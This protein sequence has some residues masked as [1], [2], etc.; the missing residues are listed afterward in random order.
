MSKEKKLKELE[1]GYEAGIVK[2]EEYLRKRKEI[3]SEAGKEEKAVEEQENSDENTTKGSDRMLIAG[4]AVVVV[5]FFGVFF[6]AKLAK[7]PPKTIEDLHRLNIEGKLKPEEGYLYK[8]VY[9]FVNLDGFWYTQLTS[10]SGKR[11]YDMSLRYGPKD[12]ENIP[13]SGFLDTELFNNA[14]EYYVT[15]NPTGRDFSH[16]AVAVADFNQH[17]V[18]VFAK[19]PIAACDK[20]ETAACEGRPIITCNNTG[21][22][23][24]YIKE[25]N[26]T[27]VKYDGNCIIVEGSGFDL[28]KGVDRILLNFY[29]IMEQ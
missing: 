17:M 6:I 20:N 1:E 7:E 3:E 19:K 8:G 15:F 12:L 9:S 10:P 29:G 5:L 26:E 11:L 4:I 14:T 22:I 24:L 27:L 21:K 16:V 18:N 13:I 28:V 2:K 25:A 23:V